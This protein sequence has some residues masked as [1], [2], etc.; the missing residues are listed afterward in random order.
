MSR[1][2]RYILVTLP[3]LLL[4]Q[5]AL[6]QQ[7]CIL[8]KAN[9]DLKVY[10]CPSENEKVNYIKV[11][12]ILENTTFERFLDFV[13]DVGNYTHWKYNTIEATI[14]KTS[15]KSMI[16]RTVV[17]A[18]W[19]VSNREMV[20]EVV[21]SY[22]SIGKNLQVITHSADFE[23]PRSN[24]LVRVPFSMGVWNVSMLGDSS[25]KI[26]YTLT[27]DPGGSVPPW[28]L[29]MAI[30]EGPYQSFSNLKKMLTGK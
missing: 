8:K 15:S 28:L 11:E 14:L 16:Y 1:F 19:P 17:E 22:D 20:T 30:A 23:Y 5:I 18:P 29:N 2:L 27:I 12:M 9:G 21:S 3:V 7:D 25:L 24:D 6:C 4:A 10:S 26:D 13:R